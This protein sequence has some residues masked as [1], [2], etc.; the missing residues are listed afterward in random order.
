MVRVENNILGWDDFARGD[1][2]KREV[3]QEEVVDDPVYMGSHWRCMS[4]DTGR[5]RPRV[6]ERTGGHRGRQSQHAVTDQRMQQ[7]RGVLSALEIVLTVVLRRGYE[8]VRVEVGCREAAKRKR[9]NQAVGIHSNAN[10]YPV[11]CRS[12]TPFPE[13]MEPAGVVLDNGVL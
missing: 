8:V 9:I 11:I 4:T 5:M 2:G 13:R 3:L 12:L 10:F 7:K 6:R 1:V